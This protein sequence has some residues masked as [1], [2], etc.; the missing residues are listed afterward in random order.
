MCLPVFREDDDACSAASEAEPQVTKAIVF[1]Y[2]TK[3]LDMLGSQL[4]Q[5]DLQ[6]KR[7]DGSMTLSQRASAVQS[8]RDDPQ[9]LLR[10]V[11]AKCLL[12]QITS[13]L[14]AIILYAPT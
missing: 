1:S 5:A 8:F 14:L 10:S 13:H 12:M 11:L 9:V 6:Y 3:A 7:L 2:F 4:D